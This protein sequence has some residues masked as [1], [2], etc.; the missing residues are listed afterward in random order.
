[1][2]KISLSV[3]AILFATAS[4]FATPHVPVKKVKQATCTMGNK[5]NCVSKASCP[6]TGGNCTCK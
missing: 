1:M 6:Q 3:A 5:A 2:K 4:V